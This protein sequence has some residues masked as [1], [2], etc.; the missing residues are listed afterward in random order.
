MLLSKF[1]GILKS[2]LQQG[3]FY[4][5]LFVV[6]LVI[7]AD[8]YS[9]EARKGFETTYDEKGEEE[10][11][12]L[13][14]P[15]KT[16]SLIDFALS[17]EGIPYHYSGNSLQGF[18]CSGFTYY[19]FQHFNVPIPRSSSQQ[20]IIGQPISTAAI[21]KGDLLFF[22]GTQNNTVGHVGIVIEEQEED[23]KFIHSS[24][25]GGGRGV[26]IDSLSQP[27]YQARFLGAR[28]VEIM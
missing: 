19:V 21:R 28:R 23:S 12:V 13:E 2:L 16:D 24:S 25:G 20:Y 17:L 1:F 22:S 27:H 10:N 4:F 26:T 6:F 11:I 8:N 3:F 7:M 9:S 18:D 15:S 14:V 5:M